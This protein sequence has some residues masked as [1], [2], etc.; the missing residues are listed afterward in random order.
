M[1]KLFKRNEFPILLI[2]VLLVIVLSF[3]TSNF[4]TVRNMVDISKGNTIYGIMALGMLCV[5]ITGGIDLSI[6]G[7]ITLTSLVCGKLL[8]NTEMGIVPIIIICILVGGLVGLINGTLVTKLKLP[9]MVITLGINSILMGGVLYYTDGDMITGLP[10]WFQDFGFKR[11]LQVGDFSIPIQVVFFI[12]AAVLTYFILHY[13]V[14]GRGVYAVG[15]SELSA[16]RVGYKVDKIKILVYVYMGMLVGLAGFINTSIVQG[17]NPNTY[18]GIDMTV[19]SI[20]VIGGA[21]TL[22]GVGSVFGTILGTILMAFINNG[23]IIAR[24]PTY[25]Q[26]IVMGIII[27]AAITID[28]VRRRAEK[29]KLVKVD[30]EE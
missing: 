6:P 4:L 17:V 30:V 19:I 29:E 7:N 3:L 28:V 14:I 11:L 15:G 13:T 23:L 2:T 18:F 22:G 16:Q 9:A 26:N 20:A 12:I 21:S 27:L 8:V 10:K 24:V 1:K 5:L 25:W